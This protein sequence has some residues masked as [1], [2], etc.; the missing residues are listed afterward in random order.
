[1]VGYLHVF[2][3]F[4]KGLSSMFAFRLIEEAIWPVY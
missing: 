2:T 4:L 3:L 1:M